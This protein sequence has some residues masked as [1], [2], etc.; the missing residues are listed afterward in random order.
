C[1]LAILW[2]VLV[3]P[4]NLLGQT[5]TVQDK[6]KSPTTEKSL[7]DGTYLGVSKDHYGRLAWLLRIN[8]KTS[9]S[10]LYMPPGLTPITKLNL[11]SSGQH[12][13]KTTGALGDLIFSFSGQVSQDGIRGRFVTERKGR[14]SSEKLSDAEVTLQ[15]IDVADAAKHPIAGLYSNWKYSE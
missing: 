15:K 12:T 8:T 2:T 7:L 1:L 10:L 3:I 6:D 5:G 13:F 11:T 14:T 4:N 9:S